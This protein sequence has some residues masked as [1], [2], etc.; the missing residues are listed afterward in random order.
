MKVET[1]NSLKVKKTE[2]GSLVASKSNGNIKTPLQFPEAPDPADYRQSV[3]FAMFKYEECSSPTRRT[4]SSPQKWK[5][6]K[7]V[8]DL[9][10][11]TNDLKMKC[12]D[13]LGAPNYRQTLMPSS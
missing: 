6:T 10:S 5:Q 9:L 1:R 11:R 8:Q 12:E 13:M 4:T 2:P 7:R 3:D